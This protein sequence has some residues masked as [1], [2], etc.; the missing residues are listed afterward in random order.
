MIYKEETLI[1]EASTY[2]YFKIN[3][4]Q[5][6]KDRNISRTKLSKIT[7]IKYDIINKYYNDRCKRID[8]GT[9]AKIC[10]VLNC[11]IQDII[12]Y[13]PKIE[14]SSSTEF[15]TVLSE[16]ITSSTNFFSYKSV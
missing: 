16:I 15:S 11:K 14:I 9:I 2:G 7:H 3:L 13:I 6:M 4:K 12:I 1:W 5:I 10:S 8:L